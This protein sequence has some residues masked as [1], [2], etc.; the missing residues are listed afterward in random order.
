[1]NS[2][3]NL[4]LEPT[5][6]LK[7]IPTL[8]LFL[9]IEASE[10]QILLV[11]IDAKAAQDDPGLPPGGA[12][13][14]VHRETQNCIQDKWEHSRCPQQTTHRLPPQQTTYD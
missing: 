1:M 3:E 12:A 11:T 6:K 7:C 5:S 10:R 4:S 14:Q 13:V 9:L 2:L 8:S